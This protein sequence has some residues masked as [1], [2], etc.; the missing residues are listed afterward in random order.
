MNPGVPQCKNCWKWGYLTLSYQS[1]I[2]RCTKYN[3]A[4]STEHHREKVQCYKENKNIN[5]VATKEEELYPYV[6]KC[7][8]YKGDHQADS[9]TC[10]YWHN[11]FNR[12]WYDKKL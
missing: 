6:L 5:R 12:E 11:R 8:N 4:Y 10:L 2:S 3:G 9:Y 1:H 7:T